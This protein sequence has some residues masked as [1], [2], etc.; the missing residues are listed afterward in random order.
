MNIKRWL[1]LLVVFLLALASTLF[2]QGTPQGQTGTGTAHSTTSSPQRDQK[3]LDGTQASGQEGT[4]K[5]Y[6]YTNSAGQRVQSPT[7]ATAVPS[8][9]TAQCR[10]GSYSFSHT[11]RGTCSR[12]GGVLKWLQ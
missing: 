12:H 1:S 2:G 8:G 5:P 11:R 3:K 6:Y 9:A 7:K 4:S 10:G